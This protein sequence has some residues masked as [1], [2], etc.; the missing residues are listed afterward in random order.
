MGDIIHR[1]NDRAIGRANEELAGGFE[2]IHR[3]SRRSFLGTALAGTV[4][5]RTALGDRAVK[6]GQ[7]VFP[8]LQFSVYDR[9]PDIWNIW[10]NINQQ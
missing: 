6:T 10:P 3:L 7:F 9:T 8:R 5:A 4:L 1:R 2:A